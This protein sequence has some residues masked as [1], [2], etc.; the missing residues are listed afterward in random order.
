[1]TE[2]GDVSG[3]SACKTFDITIEL[4]L[5][6]VAV[7]GWALAALVMTSV[8]GVVSKLDSDILRFDRLIT[9]GSLLFS[10]MEIAIDEALVDLSCFVAATDKD[11]ED[12]SVL[13]VV[14]DED[15]SDLSRLLA[16]AC[17]VMSLDDEVSLD[18]LGSPH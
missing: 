6:C 4:E 16:S 10:S 7:G 3:N 2:I 11:L 5:R 13:C 1:M 15:F 8:I 17:E 9:I 12:L 18:V 14:C